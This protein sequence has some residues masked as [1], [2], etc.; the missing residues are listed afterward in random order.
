[1]GINEGS[2]YDGHWVL[3]VSDESLNS[4]PEIKIVLYATQQK[5]KLKINEQTNKQTEAKKVCWNFL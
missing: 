2:C 5:F 1:M 3:Y 4:T